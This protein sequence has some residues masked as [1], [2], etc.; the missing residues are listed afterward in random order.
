VRWIFPPNLG[1]REACLRFGARP[2]SGAGYLERSDAAA[3]PKS[4]TLIFFEDLGIDVY[5]DQ[6][7]PTAGELVDARLAEDLP[8]MSA[9]HACGE[10]GWH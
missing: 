4:R 9:M 7:L 1:F 10:G 5:L 3:S 6:Q 8:R 2:E